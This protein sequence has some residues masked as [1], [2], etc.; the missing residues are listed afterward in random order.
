MSVYVDNMKAGLGRMVMCHMMADTSEELFA[1]V[2]TI[3]VSRK[4]LQDAETV[5][6]HFDIC[7]AKRALAVKAGALEVT[8]RDLGKLILAKRR[9]RRTV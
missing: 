7:K 4:W 6:E 5:R 9:E 8:Q 1:M 2:D 3:G